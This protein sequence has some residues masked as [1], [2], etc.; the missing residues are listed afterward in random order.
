MVWISR[1]YPINKLC[2]L[3]IFATQ[4][5]DGF[6]PLVY[7]G[8]GIGVLLSVVQAPRLPK[9]VVATGKRNWYAAIGIGRI[10]EF[11]QAVRSDELANPS[12]KEDH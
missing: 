1:I 11:R 10:G 8:R 7:C 3:G 9:V 12:S 5:N 2:R 6:T 4:R